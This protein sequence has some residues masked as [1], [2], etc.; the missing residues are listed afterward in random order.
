MLK[1]LLT[2]VVLIISVISYAEARRFSRIVTPQMFGA[3][4]DGNHDDTDAINLALKNS[5]KAYLSKGVYKTS[6]SII[7]PSNTEMWE[8]GEESRIV[9]MQK[10]G[11]GK[12]VVICGIMDSGLLP[13]SPNVLTKLKASISTDRK[14]INI[15][16]ADAFSLSKGDYILLTSGK[17]GTHNPKFSYV[18]KAKRIKREK[19]KVEPSIPYLDFDTILEVASLSSIQPVK[20]EWGVD[21]YLADDVCIHDIS[22]EQSVDEGSGM[23]FLMLS[24]INSKF[25]NLNLKGNTCIGSNFTVRCIFKNITCSFDGGAVDTPEYCIET[26]FDNLN[27]KRYGIRG[28]VIGF[29]ILHGYASIIRNCSIDF[30]GIGKVGVAEQINPIIKNNTFE[31]LSSQGACVQLLLMAERLFKTIE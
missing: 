11:F 30:G 17:V 3:I 24:C 7:V 4:A 20:T 6:S 19:I 18:V 9:N 21:A 14:Y 22:I 13:G 8:D 28:N 15:E 2:T 26:I 5:R 16:D 1:R 31:N 12:T 25:Y 29:T 10:Y 23:Y 27:G